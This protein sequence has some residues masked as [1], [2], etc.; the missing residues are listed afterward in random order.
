V[1]QEVRYQQDYETTIAGVRPHAAPIVIERGYGDCK[2]KAVL[3]IEMARRAGLKLDFAILRTTPA[4]KV[5]R[6]VPNQQFNHAIVFVPQQPGIAEPLFMDPTSDGLDVGNLR[7][8][9]QGALSLVMDPESGKWEFREIPYQG[10]ELQYDRH[11]IK[12]A[13]KSPT[14]AQVSDQVTMRGGLAMGLRHILRNEGDAKKMMETLAA[15]LFPNATLR[16]SK[17]GDKEDIWH[18]LQLSLELDG[19]QAIRPEEGSWRLAIPGNFRLPG[20]VAL[21]KRET[22]L[23]LGAPDSSVY[24]I[25]ADL[26]QGYQVVHAPKDFTVDHACF[27]L[28]RKAHVEPR[29]LTLHVEYARR[30]T[31]VGTKEYEGYREAVQRAAHLFTDD[32]TFGEIPRDKPRKK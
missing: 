26:P 21:K 22:P 4:G 23:R 3:L 8:D 13:V 31:D 6:D 12:V 5:R 24:D 1:A 17:L 15:A 27:T 28:S 30:C 7:S 20:T 32:L 29:K 2:D 18:P 14:E 16:E 19:S 25:E 9:D 11:A 10:P